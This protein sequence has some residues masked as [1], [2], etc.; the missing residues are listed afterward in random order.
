MSK[1]FFL[2]ECLEASFRTPENITN[3]AIIINH[4]Q[5]HIPPLPSFSLTGTQ[6]SAHSQPESGE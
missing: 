2:R 4:E 1:I 6:P 5:F 3:I